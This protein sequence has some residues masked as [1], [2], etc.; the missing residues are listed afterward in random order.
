MAVLTSTNRGYNKRLLVYGPPKTGKSEL[1]SKLAELFPLLWFDLENGSDVLYKLPKSAQA[2]INLVKIPDSKSN[3]QAIDTILKVFKRAKGEICHGHG[4]FRCPICSK[5]PNY[6]DISDLIDIPEQAATN[7]YI[8]VVDSITQLKMS[9]M[10]HISKGK[11][12]D[13]KFE[14]DDWARLNSML[15]SILSEVQ[16]ASYDIIFISHDDMVNTVDGKEKIV[17]VSGTRN[18]SRNTAKYFSD[19]VYAELK[20]G[21][22]VFASSTTYQNKIQTGSRSDIKLEDMSTPSLLPFFAH[23]QAA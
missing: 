2:N 22:H 1:V 21:K 23:R 3:P 12:D 15:D 11:G 10:A 8:V 9:A 20:N 5:L 13:Y 18:F 19:V 4:K 6:A 7:H 14:F 16:A 17:P